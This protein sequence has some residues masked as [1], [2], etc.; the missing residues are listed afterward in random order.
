MPPKSPGQPARSLRAGWPLIE[1]QPAPGGR[2]SRPRGGTPSRRAPGW[3]P[4]LGEAGRPGLGGDPEPP[5]GCCPTPRSPGDGTGSSAAPSQTPAPWPPGCRSTQA[6]IIHRLKVSSDGGADQ[7]TSD[8]GGETVS[9][10]PS[11]LASLPADFNTLRC[12]Q[13]L[14]LGHMPTSEFI[15]KQ[16][17]LSK[18]TRVSIHAKKK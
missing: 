3:S 13:L 8:R 18:Q 15:R 9:R 1:G 16:S 6:F 14:V 11:A 2:T 4:S 7:P 12:A 10:S 5:G 17:R